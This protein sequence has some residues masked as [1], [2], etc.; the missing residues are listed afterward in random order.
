MYYV[1][2]KVVYGLYLVFIQTQLGT[3]SSVFSY[4]G[5]PSQVYSDTEGYLVKCIQLQ[6]CIQSHSEKSPARPMLFTVQI[7]D[8]NFECSL[9][10]NSTVIVCIEL[11]LHII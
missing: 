5:V 8:I 6:R 10:C 4:I 9:G 1:T 2:S 7:T 11:L 3:Q